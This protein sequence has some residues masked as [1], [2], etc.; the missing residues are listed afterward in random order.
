MPPIHHNSKFIFEI[1]AKCELF[2]GALSNL[3]QLFATEIPLKMMKNAFYF[4]SKAFFVDFLVMKKNGLIR[5]LRL[6]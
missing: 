1:K 2:K 5:K 6:I 3:R 4:I